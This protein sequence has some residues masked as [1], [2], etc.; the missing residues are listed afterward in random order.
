MKAVIAA[1]QVAGVAIAMYA[2]RRVGGGGK[3]AVQAREQL[4]RDALISRLQAARNKVAFQQSGQRG[5]A[6]MAD[7]GDLAVHEGLDRPYRMHTPEQT[8][9]AVQ[10]IQIARLRRPAAAPWE[11]REAK[12]GVLKQGFAI[13]HDRRDYR[14]FQLAEL[15]AGV[16][17]QVRSQCGKGMR[18]A[19]KSTEEKAAVYS[20]NLRRALACAPGNRH[21]PVPRRLCAAGGRCF[22]RWRRWSVR[23]RSAPHAG[24]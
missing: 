9:E 7:A 17:H 22:R 14:H 13:A 8:A 3:Q 2:D 6:K 18:H 19:R 4:A 11:Q 21:P 15:Q 20:L 23:R 1:Q 24:L 5:I 10:L 16:Q 12:A